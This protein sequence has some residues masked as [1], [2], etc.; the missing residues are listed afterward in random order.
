MYRH[1]SK[2]QI[3]PIVL[4][5]E[6]QSDDKQEVAKTY[7]NHDNHPRVNWKLEQKSQ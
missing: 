6:E 1:I 5:K 7:E 2:E 3:T 4:D